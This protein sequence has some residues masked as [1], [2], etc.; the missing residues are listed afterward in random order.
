MRIAWPMLLD[1]TESR[2]FAGRITE[3]CVFTFADVAVVLLKHFIVL[4]KPIVR[5]A[6]VQKT[7]ITQHYKSLNGKLPLVFGMMICCFFCS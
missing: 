7:A 3:R 1:T 2:T 4:F 6:I 5:I